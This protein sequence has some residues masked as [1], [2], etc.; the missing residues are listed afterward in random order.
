MTEQEINDLG[1]VMPIDYKSNLSSD[2]SVGMD[3][4][5]V[6]HMLGDEPNLRLIRPYNIAD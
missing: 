5:S 6:D 4:R 2:P 1:P 3:E